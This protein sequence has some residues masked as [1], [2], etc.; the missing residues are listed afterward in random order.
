MGSYYKLQEA[1]IFELRNKCIFSIRNL[2][3]QD[4]PFGIFLD[5]IVVSSPRKFANT[6][7]ETKM[8]KP[9]N[10]HPPHTLTR[11]PVFANPH[12]SHVYGINRQWLYNSQQKH[13]PGSGKNETFFA[14]VCRPR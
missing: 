4:L 7:H 2:H 1:Q 14:G 13:A 8:L 6:H 12:S 10:A 3:K 5:K 9:N 11:T